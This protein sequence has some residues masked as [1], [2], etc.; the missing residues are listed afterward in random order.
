[1]T[2]GWEVDERDCEDQK[3]SAVALV[4]DSSRGSIYL[5]CCDL[6]IMSWDA[7]FSHCHFSPSLLQNKV[8][9]VAF[10]KHE[11]C[12]TPQLAVGSHLVKT[13]REK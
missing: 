6:E 11:A 4:Y 8:V 9:F 1:M 5:A 7:I 3:R 10:Q 12:T 2:W 13:Y